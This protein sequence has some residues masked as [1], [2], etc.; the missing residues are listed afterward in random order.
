MGPLLEAARCARKRLR[1]CQP[2]PMA[3][4]SAPFPR[5]LCCPGCAKPKARRHA[6]AVGWTPH[7]P[8]PALGRIPRGKRAVLPTNHGRGESDANGALFLARARHPRGKHVQ[9]PPRG[10]LLRGS[11]R[12]TRPHH[13]LSGSS[14]TPPHPRQVSPA[15]CRGRNAIAAMG[16]CLER[17]PRTRQ[18]LSPAA[19]AERRLWA[20]KPGMR[21]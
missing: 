8:H 5:R 17:R 9:R 16:C 10:R 6:I 14:T 13:G 2:R 7:H 12:A 18:R 21:G 11:G 1:W 20:G 15:D 4:R 3:R 19:V